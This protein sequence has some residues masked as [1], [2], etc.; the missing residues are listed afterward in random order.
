MGQALTNKIL[1]W[2]ISA[3]N[4]SRFDIAPNTTV[5]LD[6]V[7]HDEIV[8]I[9]FTGAIW[10]SRQNGKSYLETPNCLV[11][12]DAG[13]IFSLESAYI[14]NEGAICR[15]I[16]IS[17]QNLRRLCQ[18]FQIEFHQLDFT[19]P[20]ID[21]LL[22]RN[23]FAY[24]HKILETSDCALEKSS[25]L[26]LFLKQLLKHVATERLGYYHQINPAKIKLVMEYLRSSYN[27]NISL[28]D[29]SEI[30][31]T[32]PFVLMRNFRKSLGV[33]P[34]EYLQNYRIIQAKKLISTGISLTDVALLCGFSDQ[35]HLTRIF[36]RKVGVT[37]GNFS[38]IKE[39]AT[40]SIM[41]SSINN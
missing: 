30:T 17:P 5:S 10:K 33:T 19:N 32:N 35:S 28:E 6:R 26:T 38:I 37:P 40:P 9:G 34:H 7:F 18:S 27:S 25:Y 31:Q 2:Q 24:T 8:I 21:N 13:Q 16:K 39:T 15:E 22:L 1:N 11:I 14:S 36:K 23:Q 4:L 29:L 3:C 20:I 41:L 12:R